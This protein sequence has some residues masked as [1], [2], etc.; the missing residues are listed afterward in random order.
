M[1]DVYKAAKRAT[2]LILL[3]CARPEIKAIVQGIVRQAIDEETVNLKTENNQLKSELDNL[4][5]LFKNEI[6]EI[7][8]TEYE[9]ELQNQRVF[10]SEM[11]LYGDD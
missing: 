3:K 8:K 6:E 10:K 4:K 11:R 9:K 7:Q 2:E 5:R 1:D